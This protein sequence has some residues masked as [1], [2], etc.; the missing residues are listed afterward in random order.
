MY[1]SITCTHWTSITTRDCILNCKKPA[2][3]PT[4]T[5]SMIAYSSSV[6][7]FSSVIASFFS[8]S[9]PLEFI[10]SL[11]LSSVHFY[12]TTFFFSLFSFIS[13]PETTIF[14]QRR[15]KNEKRKEK[16]TKRNDNLLTKIVVSFC[17]WTTKKIFSTNRRMELNPR[18]KRMCDNLIQCFAKQSHLFETCQD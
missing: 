2:G 8:F 9:T 16:S 17:D 13:Y 11:T 6:S 10:I 14:F 15:E 18:E 12:Y 3:L 5:N 1:Y 4:G 7:A